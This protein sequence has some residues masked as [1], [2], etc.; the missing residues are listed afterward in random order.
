LVSQAT[1]FLDIIFSVAL[2]YQTALRRDADNQAR[3]KMNQG[4]GYVLK[5]EFLRE[6]GL[7]NNNFDINDTS[8]FPRSKPHSFKI[9][10]NYFCVSLFNTFQIISGCQLPKPKQSNKG[11]VVDPYVKIRVVG[12]AVDDHPKNEGKTKS[13]DNNGFR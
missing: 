8:T 4:A 7:L 3:F 10:V 11:E 5:P 1:L 2:N 13:I 12:P 6:E 9:K